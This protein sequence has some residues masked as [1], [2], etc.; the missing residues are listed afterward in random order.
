VEASDRV[1][2]DSVT[3]A[4]GTEGVR[5]AVNGL[6]RDRAVRQGSSWTSEGALSRRDLSFP[7]LRDDLPSNLTS[8]ARHRV[9]VGIRLPCANRLE[10]LRQVVRLELL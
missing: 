1:I 2:W 10:Q 9:N 4:K 8:R 3:I 5:R 7:F 6:T